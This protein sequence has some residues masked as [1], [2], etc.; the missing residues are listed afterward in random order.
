MDIGCILAVLLY[1][2]GCC[3]FY[4]TL[5][6][7]SILDLCIDFSALLSDARYSHIFES[8]PYYL[9]IYTVECLFVFNEAHEE[10]S[11]MI[12]SFSHQP[13]QVSNLVSSSSTS[14]NPACSIGSSWMRKFSSLFCN[15]L[16]SI[17]LACDIKAIVL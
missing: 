17:L 7:Q 6:L 12:S 13:S 8:A 5:S 16:R 10:F 15:I 11:L 14:S 1:Q 3:L 9:M 2:S 4:H